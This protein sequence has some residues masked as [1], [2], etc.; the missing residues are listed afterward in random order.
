MFKSDIAMQR[1]VSDVAWSIG[2]LNLEVKNTKLSK[3]IYPEKERMLSWSASNAVWTDEKVPLKHVAFLSLLPYPVTLYSS[4]YT[5]MKNLVEISS[6]LVQTNITVYADEKV[7][8]MAKEIQLLRPTE[9]KTLVLCLG[10][11]HTEK[12]SPA[13]H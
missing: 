10:T 9:F 6:Q 12:N 4:V 2:R 8:S 5:Q 11:F 13:M 3:I 7:Y 1:N